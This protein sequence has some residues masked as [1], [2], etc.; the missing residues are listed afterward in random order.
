[1][2]PRGILNFNLV[3]AAEMQIMKSSTKAIIVIAIAVVGFLLL[4]LG[5][6]IGTGTMM[7]GGMMGSEGVGEFS[8]IWLPILLVVAFGVFLFWV[9]PGED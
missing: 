2:N 5:G 8:G 1:M 9:M 4:I 7:N 3:L 6:G